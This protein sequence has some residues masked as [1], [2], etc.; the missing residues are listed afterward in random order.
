MRTTLAGLPPVKRII[1]TL[2]GVSS[3]EAAQTS[4][5]AA[6]AP[7]LEGVSG[8]YFSKMKEVPSSAASYDEA[9]AVRLWQISAELT[10]LSV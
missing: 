5:Y 2:M 3:E 8:K 1:N 7:E 6:S 9:A 4:I 10:A